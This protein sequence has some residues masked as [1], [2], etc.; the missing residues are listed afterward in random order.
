MP[1]GRGNEFRF[2]NGNKSAYKGGTCK[3]SKGYILILKH[4][5]PQCDIRGYVP[6]HRLVYEEYNKCCILPY[7]VIHHKNGIKTDNR[8]ENLQPFTRSQHATNDLTG[9]HRSDA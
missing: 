3:H 1:F 9:R 2:Q 8:P 5:H 4:D 7:I 6:E